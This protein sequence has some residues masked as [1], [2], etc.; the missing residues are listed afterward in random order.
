MNKYQP[1]AIQ[2]KNLSAKYWA[3]VFVNIVNESKIILIYP[4]AM[5][6]CQSQKCANSVTDRYHSLWPVGNSPKKAL[7]E[8]QQVF[9]RVYYIYRQATGAWHRWLDW[10]QLDLELSIEFW[11]WAGSSMILSP[12]SVC[13]GLLRSSYI[14]FCFKIR[15]G[16]YG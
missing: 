11:T 5:L 1:E 12:S 16:S 7:T 8:D 9:Q 13:R 4:I 14:P 2:I 6:N 10:L 3:I 15:S